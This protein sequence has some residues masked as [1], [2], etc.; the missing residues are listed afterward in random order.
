MQV[1]AHAH[2]TIAEKVHLG[3]KLA[4][5]K[6][7]ATVRLQSAVSFCLQGAL[8]RLILLLTKPVIHPAR[9]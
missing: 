2:N 9:A 6:D 5:F 3:A 7:E 1:H 4:G 8:P